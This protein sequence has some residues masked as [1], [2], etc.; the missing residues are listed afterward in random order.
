MKSAGQLERLYG[1]NSDDITLET[2]QKEQQ[3]WDIGQPSNQDESN[4]IPSGLSERSYQKYNR[5]LHKLKFGKVIGDEQVA[6]T[7][8]GDVPTTEEMSD[9]VQT[10]STT[11]ASNQPSR[12]E[13]IDEMTDVDEDYGIIIMDESQQLQPILAP[14]GLGFFHG[15]I[16]FV[17]WLIT[18]SAVVQLEDYEDEWIT[19]NTKTFFP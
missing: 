16:N 13:K 4:D 15:L 7:E 1:N 9:P 19:N 12:R 10:T 5:L 11:L 18:S 8:I 2:D 14:S 3:N 17:R 6:P